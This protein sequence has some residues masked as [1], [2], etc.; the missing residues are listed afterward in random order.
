MRRT[1]SDPLKFLTTLSPAQLDRLAEDF[2][3]DFK[4]H[5]ARKAYGI[6]QALD[7]LPQPDEPDEWVIAL[8]NVKARRERLAKLVAEAIEKN[9]KARTHKNLQRKKFRLNK[10]HIALFTAARLT[11]TQEKYLRLRLEYGLSPTAIAR[12]FGIHHST[13]Q[14]SLKAAQKKIDRVGINPRNPRLLGSHR[15]T[16]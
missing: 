15:R 13:V 10:F 16:S 5:E 2:L 8:H 11:T 9:R 12:K 1:K 7:N 4:A 14:E 3:R 6:P